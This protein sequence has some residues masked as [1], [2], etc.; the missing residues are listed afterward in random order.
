MDGGP[1][2]VYNPDA[3]DAN[4]T[5]TTQQTFLSDF[6]ALSLTSIHCTRNDTDL[7][8]FFWKDL[9]GD[10]PGRICVILALGRLWDKTLGFGHPYTAAA[11]LGAFTLAV[12]Q[13][14]TPVY[15]Q[16]FPQLGWFT[17]WIWRSSPWLAR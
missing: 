1:V 14:S 9:T 13:G 7:R 10:S 12:K 17:T 4:T 5:A 15:N 8:A 11:N 16:H 2:Y 6:S 3:P